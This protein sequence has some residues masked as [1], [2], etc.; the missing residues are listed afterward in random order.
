MKLTDENGWSELYRCGAEQLI[1]LVKGGILEGKETAS[2]KQESDE[3]GSPWA[4]LADAQKFW[5]RNK[6]EEGGGGYLAWNWD[7][8]IWGADVLLAAQTSDT[9]YGAEVQR[10]LEAWITGTDGVTYTPNGLAWGSEWGSLRFVGNAALIASVYSKAIAASDAT[11]AHRYSC[12]A[13]SQMKYILGDS[14]RSFVV[15]FG[16]NPP[17]HIH[18]RGASCPPEQLPWGSNNP[19]CDYSDF[20]LST[21]NPNVLTGALVGGPGKDDSYADKRDDYQKNEVA[22]DYNSGF[23]GV[24]AFLAGS[25]DSWDQCVQRGDVVHVPTAATNNG[26]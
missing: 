10:F 11:K 2:L 7:S 25:P 13:R 21:S 22:V 16:K 23:T 9:K 1:A 15:G 14:G 17:T 19:T 26:S 3:G 12:W 5:Q 20:S 6:D 4:L 18:H 24:L 8:S